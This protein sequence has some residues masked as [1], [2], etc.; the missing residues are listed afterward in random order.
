MFQNNCSF[1]ILLPHFLL[2]FLCSVDVR[3]YN[4]HGFQTTL[5]IVHHAATRSALFRRKSDYSSS[6]NRPFG[7]RSTTLSPLNTIFHKLR[8]IRSQRTYHRSNTSSSSSSS[9]STA[10]NMVFTTPSSII[11]QASTKIL[12]DDLI[13]E[14]VRSVPRTTVMM[15]FDPSSGWV[16]YMYQKTFYQNIM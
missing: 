12:L 13:D 6:S 15:Q 8:S 14:S 4:T 3:H 11:E 2:T 7:I 1:L 10:L 5:P 16:R 9:S